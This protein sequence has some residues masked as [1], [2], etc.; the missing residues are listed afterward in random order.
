MKPKIFNITDSNFEELVLN[1]DQPVLV[2]FWADWCGSCKI[3]EPYF[4]ELLKEHEDLLIARINVEENKESMKEYGVRHLP[5]LMLFKTGKQIDEIVG[6]NPNKIK[7]MLNE[8][9]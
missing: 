7:G 3:I 5:T 2:D 8:N 9:L 4:E 6:A 1:N